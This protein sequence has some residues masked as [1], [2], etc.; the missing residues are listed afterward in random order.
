MPLRRIS[1]VNDIRSPFKHLLFGIGGAVTASAF[2]YGEHLMVCA[3]APLQL[4]AILLAVSLGGLGGILVSLTLAN[5]TLQ[6]NPEAEANWQRI[7]ASLQVDET[8]RLALNVF[9]R[10]SQGIIIANSKKKIVTVN[11]AF[12][13]ITGLK[14]NEVWMKGFSIFLDQKHTS[15]VMLDN[16]DAVIATGQDWQGEVYGRKKNGDMFPAALQ[17][18]TVTDSQGQI[19]N[20]IGF[21]TDITIRKQTDERLQHLAMHDILTGLPNRIL[22]IDQLQNA[23]WR[24]EQTGQKV[25]VLFLDLDGF[26]TINDTMGH[27]VGDEFLRVIAKRLQAAVKNTD[28]AARMGGDE[29][30]VL[31][32]NIHSQEDVVRATQRLLMSISKPIS[33]QEQTL[34]ITASIGISIYP[35]HSTEESLLSTADQAMY[36]AKSQGKNSYFIFPANGKK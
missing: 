31:L 19:E 3:A 28:S 15:K 21:L 13:S 4:P 11:A 7:T 18:I 16:L 6:A 26:K 34:Q 17:V 10:A 9:E 1:A 25:A 8:L 5:K 29:F 30:A 22:F 27:H 23:I 12:T 35:E 20:Y 2:L 36:L 32:Q 24:A 33:L 14:K